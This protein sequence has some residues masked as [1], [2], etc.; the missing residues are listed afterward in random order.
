VLVQIT[1]GLEDAHGVGFVHGH[2]HLDSVLLFSGSLTPG[3][4]V[5]SICDWGRSRRIE[6][7]QD[8]YLHAT[9]E[10]PIAKTTPSATVPMHITNEHWLDSARGRFGYRSH[11]LWHGGSNP[12]AF[13]YAGS[14]PSH[15]WKP[16]ECRG[17]GGRGRGAR[18][19]GA[20]LHERSL[21]RVRPP[22]PA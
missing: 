22:A 16:Q 1:Q 21:P 13:Q 11:P 20:G 19:P 6:T 12:V 17:S 3:T 9:K 10:A 8:Y 4:I 2:L 18:C 15:I 5:V 7:P 14:Y